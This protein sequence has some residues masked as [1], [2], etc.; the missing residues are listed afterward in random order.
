M[1]LKD[2]KLELNYDNVVKDFNALAQRTLNL[3]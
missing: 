1:M 3:E 2:S